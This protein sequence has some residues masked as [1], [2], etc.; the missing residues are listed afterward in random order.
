MP[1]SNPPPDRPPIVVAGAHDLEA[2]I[3]KRQLEGIAELELVETALAREWARER[4]PQI[5]LLVMDHQRDEIVALCRMLAADGVACIMVSRDRDPDTIL[6][7]MRSGARDFAYLEGE[8]SDVRRAVTAIPA[9]APAARPHRG[10]VL[11]V[12][13]SKG[14]VG[15]TTLATNLAGALCEAEPQQRTVILDVDAQLGDVLTFLDVPSRYAWSELRANLA[16]LDDELVH[17]SLTEHESGI[18]VVAQ[19]GD[20]ED[21]DLIDAA[22]V[23]ET[24][25]FLRQHYDYVIVDGLRDFRE[26]SLAA[27]DA[28]DRVLLAMTQDVPALKNASRCLG[29]FRRLGYGGDKVAVVVNRF[30]KRAKLDLDTIVDALGVGI[31]ATVANDFTTVHAAIDQGTLLVKSAPHSHV[32]EDVRD[33]V[34]FLGVTRRARRRSWF[35]RAQ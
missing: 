30:Q 21:A 23:T 1:Q 4:R 26:T 12:F 10:V 8:D 13:G 19:A 29:V 11:A 3:L 14:G 28:A 22:A 6:L 16:R 15:A 7:A 18:R 25:A 27:L 24:I 5:A 20:P 35:G 2:A 9:E 33:L 31:D 34:R 17:R 32:T